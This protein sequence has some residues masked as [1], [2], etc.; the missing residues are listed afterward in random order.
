MIYFWNYLIVEICVCPYLEIRQRQVE[1]YGSPQKSVNATGII[2]LQMGKLS[3]RHD[4]TLNIAYPAEIV[5]VRPRAK[6]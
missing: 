2:N 3:R 1:L 6:S 4:K 5:L